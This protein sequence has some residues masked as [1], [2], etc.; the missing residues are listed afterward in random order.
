LIIRGGFS[1][2][3]GPVFHVDK[4]PWLWQVYAIINHKKNTLVHH[5]LWAQREKHFPR[6]W[7]AAAVLASLGPK[8]TNT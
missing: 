5:V 8:N 6:L 7:F 4:K 2:A 1:K 3:F